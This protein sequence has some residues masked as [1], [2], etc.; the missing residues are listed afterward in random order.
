MVI[1]VRITVISGAPLDDVSTL[2]AASTRIGP[3]ERC[4][5]GCA[6]DA[7]SANV[8]S[9][10]VGNSLFDSRY[11]MSCNRRVGAHFQPEPRPLQ[12]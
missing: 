8:P 1:A 10:R 4:W 7:I 6:L 9:Q 5:R 11:P 12:Q 3:P 2:D